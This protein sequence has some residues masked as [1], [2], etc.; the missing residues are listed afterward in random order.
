MNKLFI[1]AHSLCYQVL[2][3]SSTPTPTPGQHIRYVLLGIQQ[4]FC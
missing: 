2:A 4:A 3:R 1:E